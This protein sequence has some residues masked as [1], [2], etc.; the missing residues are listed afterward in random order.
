MQPAK[1]F[2]DR[3]TAGFRFI[4]RRQVQSH[5]RSG[6]RWV[7]CS[8]FEPTS[9]SQCQHRSHFWPSA[10][11]T[12]AFITGAFPTGFSS[13][14]ETFRSSRKASL[15]SVADFSASGEPLNLRLAQGPC[16]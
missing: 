7:G 3:S 8:A 15:F 1:M 6:R 4:E 12:V 13:N 14:F 16:R 11:V 5:G 10:F 9:I 2:T